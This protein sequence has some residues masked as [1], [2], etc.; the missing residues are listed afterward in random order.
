[1]RLRHCGKRFFFGL[2][3]A[4][5]FCPLWSQP[6]DTDPAAFIG[7]TLGELITRL[8]VPDSVYAVRGLEEW[9][10]DVVFVYKDKDFYI[11]K[12]KVWQLGLKSFSGVGLGTKR[13][14]ISLVLGEGVDTYE[15]YTLFALTGHSLPLMLRF[16]VDKRGLVSAIYLYRSDF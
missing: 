10:D 14:A 1:M 4:A 8:G 16:N 9:Q 2:F 6:E 15:T 11:F 12:D 13:D 7:V 5:G 3:I